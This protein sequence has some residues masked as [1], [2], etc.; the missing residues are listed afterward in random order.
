MKMKDKAKEK[1]DLHI[2]AK[3]CANTKMFLELDNGIGGF[4][5]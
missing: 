2:L 3:N 1:S 4:H 5:E